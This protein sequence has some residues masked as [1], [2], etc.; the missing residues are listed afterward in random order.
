MKHLIFLLLSLTFLFS[1][2]LKEKKEESKILTVSEFVLQA[3]QLDSTI[4]EVMGKVDHLCMESKAKIHFVCPDHPEESIK[5]FADETLKEFSDT[6]MDQI[7]VVKGRVAV[8]T[9]ID[10]AYLDEWEA[11]LKAQIEKEAAEA[12]E[13]VAAGKEEKHEGVAEP[14]THQHGNQEAMIARYRTQVEAS[15]KGYINL[16]KILVSEVKPVEKPLK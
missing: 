15:G 4:V 11:D 10:K 8:S 13:P 7:I 2:N 3:E 14:E 16:Y 9:R 5:I 1:C 6:L 12:K